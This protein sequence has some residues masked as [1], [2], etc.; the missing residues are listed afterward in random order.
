[1]AA[2]SPASASGPTLTTSPSRARCSPGA[3]DGIGLRRHPA[4]QPPAASGA[5]IRRNRCAAPFDTVPERVN[6]SPPA[7]ALPPL[8]RRV[9]DMFLVVT[10]AALPLSTTA[11]EAGLLALAALTLF[12]VFAGWSVVCRTPLDAALAILGTT[13]VISTLASGH[14][15]EASGWLG[16]WVV[17]AY[18]LTY[19]WL[20]DARHAVRLVHVL[21]GAGALAA[22]YGILQHFTGADWYRSLLGRPTFVHPRNAGSQGYAVVGFFRNY[23]T[24]AHAMLFPLAWAAALAVRGSVAGIVAA[25][26]LVV[27]IVFSTA[28]GAWLAALAGG[29]ILAMVARRRATLLMLGALAAAACLAFALAPDLRR[30]ATE[31]FAT[32]GENAARIEIYRANLD[33]VHERPIFG[34]GFGRYQRAAPPY[35]V[36]HPE[37]D[38]HSHA[39][40]DY[41]QIAAEAGLVGL[42]AFSLLYATALRKGWAAIRRAATPEVWAVAVGAW[43]A[44]WAF[45]VGGLTQ[46]NFGDSEVAIPMWLALAVLMRCAA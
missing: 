9:A 17:L 37:A 44:T 30:Q 5:V 16:R 26:L 25:P 13:F 34:V 31:M 2:V 35:Y 46:Y 6:Q 39:H 32:T 42:A 29:T 28:R 20:R 18:F 33:I 7:A 27:A 14:P 45:L 1:M 10:V 38:R 43:I 40:N 23:L 41:L 15:F 36:A 12:G 22:V 11:M 24:Y 4:P 21:V 3:P 19:W 8:A